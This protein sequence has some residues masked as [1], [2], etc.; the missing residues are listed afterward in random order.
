M[1][2]NQNSNDPCE[3]FQFPCFISISSCDQSNCCTPVFFSFSQQQELLSLINQLNQAILSF[4]T[5]PNPTTIQILQSALQALHDLIITVQPNTPNRN[6]VIRTINQLI[7]SLPTASLTQISALFQFLF[8]NLSSLISCSNI[9]DPLLQQT[10]NLI[11]QGILDSSLLNIIGIPGPTGPRGFPGPKGA[12]GPQGV[13]G[14]QG[15]DGP[16][17]ATG[18]QGV[19]GLQGLEGLAGATGPQG[20]EGLQGPEGPPGPTGP[21]GVQGLQGPPGPP[22]PTGSGTGMGVPGPPGPTGPQGVQGIQG[23]EGP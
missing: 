7:N 20:V 2:H 15:P 22:G 6:L 1:K 8:Q 16:E 23:P 12:T 10:F 13:Q 18:P 5:T 17:G 4:F 14:L 3:K 11:L 9:S 21:Q 19:Q